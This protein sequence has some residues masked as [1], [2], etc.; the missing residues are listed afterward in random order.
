MN[1][2]NYIGDTP[3]LISIKHHYM[4]GSIFLLPYNDSSFVKDKNGLDAIYYTKN[5]FKL[6]NILK[7]II[8][9]HYLS[10]FKKAKNKI[11]FIQK[12]FSEYIIGEY[13]NDLESDAYDIIN[14]KLE[15]FKR[16]TKNI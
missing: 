3:L 4:T 10:C 2:I 12:E 5:D 14:E 16:S 1:D 11:Q 8:S 15:F 13:K 7:K 9:L 6:N